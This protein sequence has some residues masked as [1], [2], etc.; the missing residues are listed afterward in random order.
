MKVVSDRVQKGEKRIAKIA[1]RLGGKKS[2][3][4]ELV[5][6]INEINVGLLE[7][8]QVTHGSEEELSTKS[9]NFDHS[10]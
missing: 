8:I 2:D 3:N 6:K 1:T 9:C 5:D 7:Q 10:K 4:D